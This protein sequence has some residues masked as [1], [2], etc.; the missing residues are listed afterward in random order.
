MSQRTFGQIH[1]QSR[2]RHAMHAQQADPAS[3]THEIVGRTA[4]LR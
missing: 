2:E 1:R 3:R 4:G